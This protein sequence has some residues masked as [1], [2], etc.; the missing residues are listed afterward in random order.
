MDSSIVKLISKS[1]GKKP[2]ERSPLDLQI[3][4]ILLDLQNSSSDL[5]SEIRSLRFSF[6]HEI[7]LENGHHVLLL[8]VPIRQIR[9]WR[10]VQVRLSR[11]LEKKLATIDSQ[12]NVVIIGHRKMASKSAHKAQKGHPKPKSRSK[13]QTFVHEAWL[14][15]LVYPVEIVG[16]RT[17]VKTDGSCIIKVL[18]DSKDQTILENRLDTLAG[19]YGKLTGKNVVFDFPLE[20]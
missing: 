16:K 12:K 20:K 14:E 1:K 2:A 11:E 10:K 9:E 7:E 13:T 8:L 17:R 3:G 19:V 4:K 6:A 18:L 15:D 5:A